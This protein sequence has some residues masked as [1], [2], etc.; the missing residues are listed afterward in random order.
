MSASTVLIVDDDV[1]WTETAAEA[2]RDAGFT[3]FLAH[4]GDQG[5]V[6]LGRETPTVVIID[7]HLPGLD[8]LQLLRDFRRKDHVTP[9]VMISGDDQTS[10]QDRAMAEGA[11][12]FLRK[13]ISLAMLLRAVSR[14][15]KATGNGRLQRR[16][17]E[18]L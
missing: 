13:P 15:A 16:S 9:V 7:V 12:A 2:L 1:P 14:Q 11:S 6:L 5:A 10:I 8:G 17:G 18:Q 3:V 4:D